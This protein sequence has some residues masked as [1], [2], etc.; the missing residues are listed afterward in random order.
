MEQGKCVMDGPATQDD[1]QGRVVLGK[2]S[3][4]QADDKAIAVVEVPEWGGWVNICVM[5]GLERDTFE[6]EVGKPA[7]DESRHDRKMRLNN[8]RARL[9]VL[10]ICDEKGNRLFEKSDA[11]ALGEKS[12][13]V[14]DRIFTAACEMNGLTEVD[15]ESLAGNS[16][17]DQSD[18]S[19]SD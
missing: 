17:G 5:S 4:L 3:I 18:D 6:A 9:A 7:G 15:I 19:G 2:D 11:A 16:E 14:L 12:A 1:P 8:M 10:T 13:A